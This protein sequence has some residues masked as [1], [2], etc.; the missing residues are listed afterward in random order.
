MTERAPFTRIGSMTVREACL[1]VIRGLPEKEGITYEQAIREISELVGRDVDKAAIQGP[2]TAA[3]DE[4]RRNFGECGLKT[5]RNVGWQ[6]QNPDEVVHTGARYEAS[7]YRSIKKGIETISQVN[8]TRLS[9]DARIKRDKMIDRN[10][11]LVEAEERR[12]ERRR[13]LGLSGPDEPAQSG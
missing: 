1:R 4:L 6:R 2:M 9:W 11:A 8:T 10:K 13:Q 3:G 5:L 7:G 12:L